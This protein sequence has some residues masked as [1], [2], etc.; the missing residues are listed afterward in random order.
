M[1]F[2]VGTVLGREDADALGSF[3]ADGTRCIFSIK[4]PKKIKGG[5][6]LYLIKESDGIYKYRNTVPVNFKDFCDKLEEITGKNVYDSRL[7]DE[8][9]IE[10]ILR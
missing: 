4:S 10:K 5:D 3:S 6:F 1:I 8:M 9:T 2:P 7:I